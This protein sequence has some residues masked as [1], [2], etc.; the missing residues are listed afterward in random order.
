MKIDVPLGGLEAA[1]KQYLTERSPDVV[2]FKSNESVLVAVSH[3][4]LEQFQNVFLYVDRQRFAPGWGSESFTVAPYGERGVSFGRANRDD[5]LPYSYTTTK[6]VLLDR[7][8]LVEISRALR[9]LE[10]PVSIEVQ[11]VHEGRMT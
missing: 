1:I 10:R 9:A 7:I 11:T 4:F 3:S 6:P 2:C 5:R 8:L